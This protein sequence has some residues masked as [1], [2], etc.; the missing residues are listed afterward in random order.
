LFDKLNK[1]AREPLVHFLCMGALIYG[2]NAVSSGDD[3]GEDERVVTVTAGEVQALTEQ[4]TRLWNRPPT[5]EE[6]AGV[7]R[8]H[9][10]RQILYREAMA[11]GLDRGDIVIERRLAQKVE[12][13]AQGLNTPGEPAEDELRRW[14][15]ANPGPFQSPDRYTITHIFFDPDKRDQSTLE[16]AQA[17]LEELG[18][19]T[20]APADI[21]PWGDRFMLQNYYPDRS[22]LELRKLF[23]TGFV[24][25]L[26]GLEPGRWHGPVLSGYGTHLVFV[27]DVT[28]LPPP[29]FEDIRNQVREAW[30]A[31]RVGELSEQ[32]L[33]DLVERYEIVVEETEV[34]LTVPGIAATP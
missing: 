12:L 26:V 21:S 3:G 5:G 7:I 19:S 31:E 1:L 11:M 14:Y 13:L 15:E 24:E 9:V 28:R 17:V 23:G 22:E 34:P 20:T 33:D 6:F 16:D 32:F 30:M 18:T 10:R 29:A 4:W 8:D 25:T 2:L 27:H